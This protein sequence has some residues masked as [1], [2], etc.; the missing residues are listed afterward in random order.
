MTHL[1]SQMPVLETERLVLRGWEEKDFDCIAEI[2]AD[3]EHARYIGG[4]KPRWQSWRILATL[5]GHYQLRGFSLFAV[6][7]KSTSNTV[8]WC[9]P[10]EPDGWPEPEIGYT[11]HPSVTGKGYATE[12]ATRTL[13]HAYEDLGWTT[14]ISMIAVE[15]PASKNVAAKLGAQFE[16]FGTLFGDTKAE[17]WRHLPPQQFQERFA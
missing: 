1:P 6:E 5:I 14:A 9:G 11:F 16:K 15:N 7:E 8:G 13:R 3:E 10:W 12:A 17:I 2:Y 4:A